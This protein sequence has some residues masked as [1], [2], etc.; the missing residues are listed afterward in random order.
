M[1]FLKCLTSL[2]F[3]CLSVAC[4]CRRTSVFLKHCIITNWPLGVGQHWHVSKPKEKS[5]LVVVVMIRGSV[6]CRRF[7]F[8]PDWLNRIW[9][10]GRYWILIMVQFECWRRRSPST[11]S[12]GGPYSG[13]FSLTVK[14]WD[15]ISHLSACMRDEGPFHE[16]GRDR[17][18]TAFSTW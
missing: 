15:S 1:L 14:R 8:L 2:H 6:R 13:Y 4:C 9:A 12:F 11:Y 3:F 10:K 7:D 5:Y 17:F 18:Q 16:R